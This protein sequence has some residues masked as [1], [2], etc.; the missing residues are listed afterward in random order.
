ML[1]CTPRWPRTKIEIIILKRSLDLLD[2][3]RTIAP[4]STE[5]KRSFST[6]NRVKIPKR[7]RLNDERTSD[8]TLLSHEK[9]LANAMDITLSSH[10]LYF[11][12]VFKL[13]QKLSDKVMSL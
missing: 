8:F 9:E 6:M 1:Q 2:L 13:I 7:S 4:T 11:I 10:T 5:A 12:A 3:K